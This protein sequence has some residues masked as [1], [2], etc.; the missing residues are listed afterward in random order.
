MVSTSGEQCGLLTTTGLQTDLPPPVPTP[1]AQVVQVGNSQ[2]GAV[3]GEVE[4]SL[5]DKTSLLVIMLVV[6]IGDTARGIMFPTLWPYV[7]ILG[8]DR[9]TQGYCVGA[10][11]FGRVFM[12]PIMGD[13]STKRGYGKILSFASLIICVGS[14]WYALASSTWQLVAAQQ[15][16]MGMGSGTLGVTRGY[17][18]NKSTTAQRTYLLANV[19]AVQYA[20]FTC[21]PFVGGFLSYILGN[22]D[23]DMLGPLKL[24]QFTAPAYV[25]V[26]LSLVIFCL[27]NTV[28]QDS[29]PAPKKVKRKLSVSVP[30]SM[31]RI[32]DQDVSRFQSS[33]Q[34]AQSN[35][36]FSEASLTATNSSVGDMWPPE[37]KD[38]E[39]G[40]NEHIDFTSI[41]LLHRSHTLFKSYG[42]G[43][44]E[45]DIE[46]Q[47]WGCFQLPTTMDMLIFGGFLLNMST[48]GTIACYETLGAEY[49]M[50]HFDLTSSEAGVIFATF[51]SMGV[52]ALLSMRLLCKYFNDVQIVVG[53]MMVMIAGCA[54]FL[55][56]PHGAEGLPMF[57]WAVFLM[58]AVG[59]PIGHTAVLG[60]FS[61][62]VGR[63]PQGGLLGWFGS[64]GSV[65]RVTF[66]ILAG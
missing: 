21:M 20:G 48:K 13:W 43:R 22:R 27:L 1:T 42:H 45:S 26:C 32:A 62:V 16:V 49:S 64:A 35:P 58:Y 9:I 52:V 4:P 54:L 36:N 7:K 28:F 3:N 29:I 55:P 60:L 51:G 47:S 40:L 19:T 17:V 56:S 57:M 24:N 33:V 41:D 11:S 66:P 44:S 37:L 46:L 53:G 18:A 6:L 50:T 65:A 39:E 12:A 63:Q 25:M 23:I 34:T 38:E 14:M 10:F 59:Y 61:K 31:T 2:Y 30:H 8:G 15:V 5:E